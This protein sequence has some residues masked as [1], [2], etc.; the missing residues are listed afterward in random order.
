LELK[1]GNARLSGQV[2]IIMN[3]VPTERAH[4]VRP[5][6]Q[7]Q[8]PEK[9]STEERKLYEQLRALKQKPKQKRQT[10]E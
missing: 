1:T 10:T 5:Q 3:E 4:S 9:L 7:W 8:A 2:F 6:K